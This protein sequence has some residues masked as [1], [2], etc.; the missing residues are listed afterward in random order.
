[1]SAVRTTSSYLEVVDKNK[2]TWSVRCKR[3]VRISPP[4]GRKTF[5]YVSAHMSRTGTMWMKSWPPSTTTPLYSV[6]TEDFNLKC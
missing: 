5:A 1:M 3:L 4:N 6:D 2:L